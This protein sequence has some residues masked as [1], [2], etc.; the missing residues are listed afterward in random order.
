MRK[1]TRHTYIAGID[2]LKHRLVQFRQSW[3]THYRCSYQTVLVYLLKIFES[4]DS[5]YSLL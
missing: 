5:R 2:K 4:V 1:R 3:T